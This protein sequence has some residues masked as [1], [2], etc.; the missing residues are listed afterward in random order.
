MIDEKEL[1]DL[2]TFIE[3]LEVEINKGEELGFDRIGMDFETAKQIVKLLKQPKVGE[4]I[5]VEE[6]L[7]E[8]NQAVLTCKNKQINILIWKSEKRMWLEPKGNWLWSYCMVEKWQPL[9]E[10]YSSGD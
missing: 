6:R 10:P 9:P 3:L 2:T 5:P 1:I 7:P 8:D 4:W